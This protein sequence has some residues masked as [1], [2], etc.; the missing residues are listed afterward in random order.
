M[1]SDESSADALQDGPDE[2][3]NIKTAESETTSH[4]ETPG[5]EPPG[6]VTP[7]AETHKIEE[8][9]AH[10]TGAKVYGPSAYVLAR[11][12]LIA[13]FSIGG[14]G[15]AGH[16]RR[17]F[18][19]S[20][21]RFIKFS[22][23]AVWREDMNSFVLD[24]M[25]EGIMEDLRYLSTLCIEDDRHYIMKCH[26]WDDVKHKHPGAALWFGDLEETEDSAQ[27]ADQPGPYA[28]YS[29]VHDRANASVAVH[30]MP[31]LLGAG[32]AAKIKQEATVFADGSLFMLAGR[33]STDLQLK[34][35]KLQG[36]LAYTKQGEE[37]QKIRTKHPVRINPNA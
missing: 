25:R 36:Y 8:P 6:A 5:A 22:G 20:S 1:D 17:M 13:G 9:A 31:R 21:S 37:G 14:S 11:E 34:L 29:F 18:G 3:A 32:G 33:R 23:K 7:G 15:F 35:W 24:R 12:D 2:H 19:G 16:P 30:N 28:I 26:S 27:R 4:G 10:A